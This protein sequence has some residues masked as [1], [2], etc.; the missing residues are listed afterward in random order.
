M[1]LFLI[2]NLLCFFQKNGY[3]FFS[4]FIIVETYVYKFYDLITSALLAY[5]LCPGMIITTKCIF[6]P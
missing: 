5:I 4:L 6:L 2:Y 3:P 1:N